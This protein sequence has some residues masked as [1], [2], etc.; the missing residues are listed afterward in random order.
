[1]PAHSTREIRE[2]I[3]RVY[4]LFD[5]FDIGPAGHDQIKTRLSHIARGYW[6]YRAKSDDVWMSLGQVE[7]SLRSIQHQIRRAKLAMTEPVILRHLDT[8]HPRNHEGRSTSQDLSEALSAAGWALTHLRSDFA[9]F[10]RGKSNRQRRTRTITRDE[11]LI[12]QLTRMLIEVLGLAPSERPDEMDAAA[13][14]IRAILNEWAVITGEPAAGNYGRIARKPFRRI[15]RTT[16]T[17]F[18]AAEQDKD[19]EINESLNLPL[20]RPPD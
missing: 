10:N 14:I 13:R 9:Q 15:I 4:Q 1:M 7:R 17:D 20:F 2:S 11:Y 5:N 19:K 3:S 12:P 8:N 16:A 6:Q 18:D